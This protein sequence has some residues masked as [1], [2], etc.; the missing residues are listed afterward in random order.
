MHVCLYGG[1]YVWVIGVGVYLWREGRACL[2][3][4]VYVCVYEW[5]VCI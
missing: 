1:M 2:C 4:N 5:V 3:V